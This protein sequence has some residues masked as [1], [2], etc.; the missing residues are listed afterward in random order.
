[1]HMNEIY[2]FQKLK[3][4]WYYI[5]FM[6]FNTDFKVIS[7]WFPMSNFPI[8]S[9]TTNLKQLSLKINIRKYILNEK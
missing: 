6:E 1:M 5:K 4:V 3:Y 8:T 9:L 7:L 2:S